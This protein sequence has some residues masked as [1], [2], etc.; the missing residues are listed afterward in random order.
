[1]CIFHVS[2]G[3]VQILEFFDSACGDVSIFLEGAA[4]TQKKSIFRTPLNLPA[5]TALGSR[6]LRKCG[7][8]KNKG[9]RGRREPCAPFPLSKRADNRSTC[10]NS[11][12]QSKSRVPSNRNGM[13]N[14]LEREEI[15]VKASSCH[16]IGFLCSS[17][18]Q[19]S[20]VSPTSLHH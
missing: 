19:L 3:E 10:L 6:D 5:D 15:E 17:T 9:H 20:E 16:L 1:M 8:V 11:R 18:Q 12:R 14:R 4:Q 2:N 13:W 7:I